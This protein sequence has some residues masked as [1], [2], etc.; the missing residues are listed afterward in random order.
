ME[1]RNAGL[2]AWWL[3]RRLEEPYQ[4]WPGGEIRVAVEPGSAATTILERLESDGVLSDA[5]LAR[6]YLVYGLEDPPLQAGEYLFDRP[7]TI[8]EVLDMLIRGEVLTHEVTIVEGLTL[9]ET[10]DLLA[11]AGF[12]DRDA[13]VAAMSSPALIADLDPEARTLEGYL[14]PSTYRFSSGTGEKAIV[15]TLVRTFRDTFR[16]SVEPLVTPSGAEAPTVH[17]VTTLASIVEKEARIDAERPVIAGVYTNRLRSGIA[18]YAD[19]TVIYALRLAGRWDGNI[20]RGD[21][22]IDSPYNTYLYPGLPPGPIASPGRSSLEAAAAPAEV[23]YL[24]FVSRNDGTHVFASTLAEHNRNVELWQRRYWRKKWA[25]EKQQG[26]R[27]ISPDAP[28]GGE[29]NDKTG[30]KDPPKPPKGRS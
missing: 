7:R 24:Y 4:G 28:A 10:A 16:Q 1:I 23:P 2:T 27:A 19:P 25:E 20:R 22:K 18:L 29:A 30:P 14:F 21:L 15:E 9:W 6:L 17:Q 26:S 11:K 12:G 13:F 3:W 5:R 8:P